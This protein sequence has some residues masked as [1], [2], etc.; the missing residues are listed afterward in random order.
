[1]FNKWR[2]ISRR[3]GTVHY[4]IKMHIES[5]ALNVCFIAGLDAEINKNIIFVFNCMN[6]VFRD[7]INVCT[8]MINES[9]KSNG[10]VPDRVYVIFTKVLELK[11]AQI[12]LIRIK[13]L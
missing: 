9:K 13:L 2:I 7:E 4:I 5:G 3:K 8:V 11:F 6:F 1:M 12:F 10:F